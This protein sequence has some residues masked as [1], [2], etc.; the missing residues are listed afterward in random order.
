MSE[1]NKYGTI[2]NDKFS[3]F[4]FQDMDTTW[5]DM[6][7][8]LDKEMPQSKKRRFL[9]WLNWYTGIALFLLGLSMIALTI[10]GY[11]HSTENVAQAI[12]ISD[13][14]ISHEE[15][16]TSEPSSSSSVKNEIPTRKSFST[17][18]IKKTENQV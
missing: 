7:D 2:I 12:T 8:I 4:S 17:T 18:G 13:S 10:F 16:N 9:L 5:L 1:N 15:L 6:K 11:L 14:E 3:E